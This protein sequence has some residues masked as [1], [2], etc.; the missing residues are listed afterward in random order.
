MLGFLDF[1][2]VALGSRRLLPLLHVALLILGVRLLARLF[3]D[4]VFTIARLDLLV[5]VH[6]ELVQTVVPALALPPLLVDAQDLRMIPNLLEALIRGKETEAALVA[7]EAFHVQS[8]LHCAHPHAQ[9]V[10]VLRGKRLQQHPSGP[11]VYT[12]LQR[13]KQHS[14]PLLRAPNHAVGRVGCQAVLDRFC[15]AVLE[16]VLRAEQP[17]PDEADHG[18]VLHQIVLNRCARQ[19]DATLRSHP[20]E[21]LQLSGVDGLEPMPLVAD[22]DVGAWEHQ[23]L[24]TQLPLLRLLRL[25]LGSLGLLRLLLLVF[26]C[27]AGQC[28]VHLVPN[29]EHAANA[30]PSL[31]VLDPVLHRH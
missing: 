24:P 4:I 23:L 28:T 17:V 27:F 13:V 6:D 22:D 12:G 18:V 20:S 31:D 30:M 14:L 15:E 8:T 9:D 29:D 19:Q 11:P 2:P 1:L 3:L 25:L 5:A 7:Q 21:C 26:R 16:L 10:L